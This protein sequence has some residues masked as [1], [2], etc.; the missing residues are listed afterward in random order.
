M[1]QLNSISQIAAN[2]D[3]FILDIWGVIHDGELLYPQV[4]PCLQALR[5][6]G[7]QICFLSN[8]PRRA[9]KVAAAL[10]KFGIGAEL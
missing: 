1:K 7:K 8:A 10:G 2:Y 6:A 9:S 4:L 3:A 5:A